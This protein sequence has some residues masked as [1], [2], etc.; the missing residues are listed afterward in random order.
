M[1]N[2][3]SQALLNAPIC[4]GKY[5]MIMLSPPVGGQRQA[6]TQ[7]AS[8]IASYHHLVVTVDHAFQSGAVETESG[9]VLFNLAGDL[10]NPRAANLG[11]VVDL[12]AVS[13]HF[14][15]SANLGP[16][17]ST[18]GTE[19]DLSNSFVFGHGQGGIVAKMMAADN[20]LS[21]GGTL[22]GLIQMP[23]PYNESNVLYR[24]RHKHSQTPSL[25]PQPQPTSEP[26]ADAG[27]DAKHS[28]DGLCGRLKNMAQGLKKMIFNSLSSLVCRVVST[29]NPRISGQRT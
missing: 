23:A 15:D 14:N 7:L 10:L 6:Y 21:S 29:S 9:S 17:L 19:I 2:M 1:R 11:R 16:L 8:D 26:K 3:E 24:P 22:D 18:P 5:P 13:L 4:S 20:L 28:N 25:Q 27:D 12:T